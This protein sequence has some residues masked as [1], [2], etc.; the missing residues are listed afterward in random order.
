MYKFFET[1]VNGNI[2]SCNSIMMNGKSL[3][4]LFNPEKSESSP[5]SISIF[6]MNG[7]SLIENFLSIDEI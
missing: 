2:Q 6:K 5:L 1:F 3:I 4:Q 7:L